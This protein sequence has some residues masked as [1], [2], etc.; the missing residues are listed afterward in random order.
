MHIQNFIKIHPFVLKIMRKNTFLHQ[1]RAITLLFINEFS[2]FTIP[3]HSSLMSMSMQSLKK[4]SQKLL[5]LESGNNILHQ[6]RAIILLFMNEFSPFAIPNYSS[7]IWMSMQSLK[8]IDQKLLKLESGNE[9]LTDGRTAGKIYMHIWMKYTC[10]FDRSTITVSRI[11][12]VGI[13]TVSISRISWTNSIGS[14]C[15]YKT[16]GLSVT[17]I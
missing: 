9:A 8:K 16:Y 13:K 5:K 14:I 15:T 7:P 3:N 17:R 10:T 6:S 4:I 2:P 1:S 11:N 12:S